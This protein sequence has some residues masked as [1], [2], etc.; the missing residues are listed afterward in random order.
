MKT[1]SSRPFTRE[2]LDR[3]KITIMSRGRW[4]NA[5]LLL[6]RQ[7]AE[8]WVVKDFRSCPAWVHAGWGRF[9]LR[10]ELAAL[11]RLEGVEGVP[12][13][14]FRLDRFALAYRY[15]PGRTLNSLLPRQ[16]DAAYF[17]ALEKLVG[18][19]HRRGVAHLDIRHLSN[20]LVTDQG[21][22]LLLDFQSSVFID[23]LPGGLRQLLMDVDIS[24]VYKCWQKLNPETMNDRQ[25]D[26]LA[27]MEKKRRFWVLKGYPLGLKRLRGMKR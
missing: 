1:P 11:N 7:G 22:P 24:G 15:T 6:Y 3:D 12:A 8:T 9:M 14:A 20:V 2:R 18:E 26:L 19:I 5:D 16:I 10:R 21:R 13:S 17:N 4:G 25:R 27:E 23:R